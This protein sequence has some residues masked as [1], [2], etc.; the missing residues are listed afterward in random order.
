MVDRHRVPGLVTLSIA[1][2]L[3]GQGCSGDDFPRQPISGFVNLDGK[4]LARGVISFYPDLLEE[5]NYPVMGGACDQERQILDPARAWIDSWPLRRV[6][7]YSGRAARATF[8]SWRAD[9]Q[10][11]R[12]RPSNE[13][14]RNTIRNRTSR[15]TSR[16][17][18]SRKSRSISRR[19]RNERLI[20]IR[21][22]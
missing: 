1:V 20:H 21:R 4:P 19:T 18:R 6:A 13:S 22:L 17:P 7:I 12:N 11:T 16:M 5:H 14:R 10:A 2:V 3:G 15:S 9:R 8:R